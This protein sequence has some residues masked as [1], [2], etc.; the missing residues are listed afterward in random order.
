MI[1]LFYPEVCKEICKN[2]LPQL[3]TL[4]QIFCLI[5]TLYQKL[6][7]CQGESVMC[8]DFYR[9]FQ[10]FLM[11][12]FEDFGYYVLSSRLLAVVFSMTCHE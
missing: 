2:E 10:C 4:R 11:T 1:I 7:P 9:G 8:N 3:I 12:Y 6:Y 5:L